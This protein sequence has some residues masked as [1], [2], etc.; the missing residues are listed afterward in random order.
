MANKPWH[1]FIWTWLP[2]LSGE[3]P[4]PPGS[5]VTR[6]AVFLPELSLGRVGSSSCSHGVTQIQ[7]ALIGLG[8]L[9]PRYFCA[10]DCHF[11]YLVFKK[12]ALACHQ[13]SV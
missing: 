6:W 3:G 10:A 13:G 7:D 12:C 9:F 2:M 11:G 5:P 1:C 4:L 8:M